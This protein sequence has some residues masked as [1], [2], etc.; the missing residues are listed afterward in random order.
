MGQAGSVAFNRKKPT[1]DSDSAHPVLRLSGTDVPHHR[2]LR[3]RRPYIVPRDRLLG[4]FTAAAQDVPLL[5]LVAPAG[6][7]KTTALRQWAVRDGR[8]IARVE[9][10][11]ADN[12]PIQLLHH[13]RLALGRIRPAGTT[14]RRESETP[15]DEALPRLLADVSVSKPGLLL[16]LDGMQALRGSL[17]PDLVAAVVDNLGSGSH[18]VAISRDQPGLRLGGLRSQGRCA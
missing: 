5:L 17:G 15:F 11:D 18:V 4:A 16:V 10:T 8:P 3:L 14:P 1:A 13:I 12:E 6:Y 7:G 2:S 9:L